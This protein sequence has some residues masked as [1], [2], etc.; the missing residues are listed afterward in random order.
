[1]CAPECPRTSAG[2]SGPEFPEGQ[3]PGR[4]SVKACGSRASEHRAPGSV[5]ARLGARVRAS[6]SPMVVCVLTRVLAWVCAHGGVR[7]AHSVQPRS[8]GAAPGAWSNRAEGRWLLAALDQPDLTPCP[9][10]LEPAGLTSAEPRAVCRGYLCCKSS[11]AFNPCGTCQ[12]PVAELVGAVLWATKLLEGSSEPSQLFSQILDAS[13]SSGAAGDSA[14]VSV[15]VPVCAPVSWPCCPAGV[16]VC[17]H[18][19][20]CTRD[21]VCLPVTVSMSSGR[22]AHACTHRSLCPRRRGH[23]ACISVCVW[24]RALPWC[25]ISMVC[26]ACLP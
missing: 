5:G 24:A 2:V 26:D 21:R 15:C 7:A 20:L 13:T 17:P 8:P 3:A 18:I 10:Q 19:I 6:P 4:H 9:H 22:C 11:E 1:M 23:A 12:L 14:C 16:S 25:V